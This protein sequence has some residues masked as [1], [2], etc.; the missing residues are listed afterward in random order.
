MTKSTIFLEAFEFEIEDEELSGTIGRAIQELRYRWLRANE[1]DCNA[2]VPEL[3]PFLYCLNSLIL[4]DEL[5]M[6]TLTQ[7]IFVFN[8]D[9]N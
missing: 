2:P 3:V 1:E 5:Y 7:Q 9:K 6:H 4:D 8:C